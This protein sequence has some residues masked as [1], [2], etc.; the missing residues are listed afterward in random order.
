MNFSYEQNG[1][2]KKKD[3]KD[4]FPEIFYS[5]TLTLHSDKFSFVL[6]SKFSPLKTI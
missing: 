6:A 2:R 5:E 3:W 1:R 4:I